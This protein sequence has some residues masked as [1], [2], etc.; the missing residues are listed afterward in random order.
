[1]T[2]N[3]CDLASVLPVELTHQ[4]PTKR[5]FSLPKNAFVGTG[6]IP[7]GSPPCHCMTIRLRNI[8]HYKLEG[9][10]LRSRWCRSAGSR[11]WRSYHWQLSGILSTDS[12]LCWS[13][14][15]G[16]LNHRNALKC[17]RLRLDLEPNGKGTEHIMLKITPTPPPVMH[18]SIIFHQWA[19]IS[20]P[21][22]QKWPPFRGLI[23]IK[24]S[25]KFPMAQLAICQH[26]LR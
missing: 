25:L 17:C 2:P 19:V 13:T 18:L 8:Y 15:V 4:T 10:H 22:G 9:R 6:V 12:G 16:P 26:C 11:C 23:S 24:I 20:S 3:I 14:G 7:Y 21:P 1:M 5:I